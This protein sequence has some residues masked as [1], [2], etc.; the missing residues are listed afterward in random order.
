MTT[1]SPND[2]SSRLSKSLGA[3]WWLYSH[4]ALVNQRIVARQQ[5]ETSPMSVWP[6]FQPSSTH[7]LRW[8]PVRILS[9]TPIAMMNVCCFC[10]RIGCQHICPMILSEIIW[11]PEW[12]VHHGRKESASRSIGMTFNKKFTHTFHVSPVFGSFENRACTQ[13][14]SS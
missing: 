9:Y 3:K 8:M 12:L 14:T 10:E 4:S 6:R 5:D 7:P 1:V 2:G 11:S 13:F